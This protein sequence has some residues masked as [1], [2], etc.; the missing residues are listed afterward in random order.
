MTPLNF[1]FSIVAKLVEPLLK[2][3]ALILIATLNRKPGITGG[4]LGR[5]EDSGRVPWTED[6]TATHYGAGTGAGRRENR[7]NPQN[8]SSCR[9]HI[10]L[11]MTR[12]WLCSPC[13]LLQEF[14]PPIW[15]ESCARVWVLS[16]RFQPTSGHEWTCR[17]GFQTC[18]LHY[19]PT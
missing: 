8:F 18:Y 14:K 6:P 7:E 19:R 2:S 10:E 5:A 12:F 4:A 16:K 11:R 3:D 1:L 15:V 17:H 13:R 9:A